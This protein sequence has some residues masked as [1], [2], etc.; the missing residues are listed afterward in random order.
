MTTN[1]RIIAGAVVVEAKLEAT[2]CGKTIAAALPITAS[3]NEWG[4][5][6]YFQ[7]PVHMPLDDT[8]TWT[9]KV[10]DIGY[11]PPGDAIAIFFGPTPLSSGSDPV[12]A[13]EVNLIGRITGD[14]TALKKAKGTSSIRIEQ[15]A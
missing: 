13:S 14:P 5:E 1:I 7:V 6:F 9:V 2:P 4:D 12:P 10:G 11:W 15:I 8:A 3:P